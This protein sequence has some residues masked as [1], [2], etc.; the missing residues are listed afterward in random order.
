VRPLLKHRLSYNQ[1]V[2]SFG[3]LFE[4]PLRGGD[5]FFS[6][7]KPFGRVGFL[8]IKPTPEKIVIVP[9]V[10]HFYAVFETD[11]FIVRFVADS[12]V[13]VRGVNRP[14]CP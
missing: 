3:I 1:L 7:T 13:I 14:A 5:N 2:S 6:R 10:V 9:R 4:P 12:S 8:G 11:N